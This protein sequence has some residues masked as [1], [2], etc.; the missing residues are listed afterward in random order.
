[1]GYRSEIYIKIDIEQ[2]DKLDT[3]LKEVELNEY[4]NSVCDNDWCYY[5]GSHLK[6]YDGYS[7]VDKVNDF[8]EDFDDGI[9]G[10]LAIGEDNAIINYGDTSGVNL[11][12]V[13]DIDTDYFIYP[14]HQNN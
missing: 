7:D 2:K 8:I 11:Y 1:M 4:F 9:A 6:W 12:A 13:T 10:L 3:L 14:E 5:Y